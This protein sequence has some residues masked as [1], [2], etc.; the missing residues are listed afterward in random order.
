MNRQSEELRTQFYILVLNKFLVELSLHFDDK[1]IVIMKGIAACSPPSSSFLSY[2]DLKPFVEN[3]NT[4]TD[5]LQVEVTL[6]NNTVTKKSKIKS[7]VAFRNYLYSSQ[8]AYKSIFQ[9]TQIALTIAV[10]SAEC[11]RSFSTLK[12]IKTRLR[13]KMTEERLADLAILAI[14][15]EIVKTLN[16]DDILDQFA[17]S[18]RNR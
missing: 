8:P 9:L 10:T 2:E 16:F 18:D 7:M 5:T 11:E 15:R 1:N 6:L 4:A 14:E 17:A 3:Y 13:T 12:L